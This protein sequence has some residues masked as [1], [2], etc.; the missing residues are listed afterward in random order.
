[1]R[2]VPIIRSAKKAM[3]QRERRTRR[4]RLAKGKMRRAVRDVRRAKGVEEGQSRLR[5]AFR[6]IDQTASKR[7]IPHNTGNRLKARLSRFVARLGQA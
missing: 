1:M 7:V 4:N 2:S 3:R 6:V 5:V